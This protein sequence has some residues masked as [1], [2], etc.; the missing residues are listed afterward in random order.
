MIKAQQKISGTFRSP[1]DAQRFANIRSYLSTARKQGLQVL[2]VIR[3]VFSGQP[4]M[5]GAAAMT[6]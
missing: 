1:E 6:E 5:P 4:W 3:P 2:E